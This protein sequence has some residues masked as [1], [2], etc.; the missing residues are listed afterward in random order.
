MSKKLSDFIKTII[1]AIVVTAA[2]LGYRHWDKKI[3][4]QY[5]PRR[6][7]AIDEGKLY[8]SGCLHEKLIEKTLKEHNIQV[9]VSLMGKYETEEIAAKNLGIELNQYRLDGDGRG[10]ITVYANAL[11]DVAHAEEENKPVL[12]HCVSGTMRSGAFTAF[13]RMLFQGECDSKKLIREMRK[14]NWKTDQLYLPE[15][16]NENMYTL[17][18]MLVERGVLAEIPDPLPQLEYK[19]VKTYT[20][21]E[22]KE[23]YENQTPQAEPEQAP[24]VEN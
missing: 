5:I 13:Y 9:I 12:I 4:D 8:R 20:L 10:D 23:R 11:E 14:Y 15:Y 6:F 16:M 24:P 3:K 19:G 2:I 7:A 18:S 17:C 1:I 21:Q 22:L